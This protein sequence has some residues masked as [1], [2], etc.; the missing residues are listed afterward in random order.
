[1][2]CLAVVDS[3][4]GSAASW[5]ALRSPSNSD[6]WVCI[7]EPASSVKG[8]GMNVACTPWARATSRTTC[9][10]VITLSAIDER[11]GVAQ[12]DLLLAR[13]DL[14]VAELHRDA[15]GLQREDR[16]AAE[17]VRHVVRGQVEVA[18]G[19]GRLRR[20]AVVGQVTEQEELDL[21][22]GVEGEAHVGG[23][24]Q[25]PAQHVPRVGPRRRAVG[26]RDVA[27]HPG[28]VAVLALGR[29][30]HLEGARVGLGEHV[31]LVDPGEA[32]DRRA[33]EADALGEGRLDLGRG[34]G[35][36][37]EVARDVGEPQPHETD[38][39]LF[40]GAQDELLLSV[41]ARP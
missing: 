5:K 29:G 37:L 16:L 13:R 27:E 6:R 9:R 1:M 21:G 25:R 18:A 3:R 40:E 32:L 2:N 14:V 17:V 23:L 19:V 39:A 7:A 33:V 35:D 12:V 8:L 4:I 22:V 30:H 41:H 10:S 38:V 36:G 26:Q 15:H 34:D 31:G 24:G 11:V 20:G 28:G